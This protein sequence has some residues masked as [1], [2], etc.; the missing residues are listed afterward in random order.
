M[1]LRLQPLH[2]DDLSEA[3]KAAAADIAPS[4]VRIR[5][6][7]GPETAGLSVSSRV[8]TGVVVSDQREILTSVF[9]FTSQPAAVFVEDAAGERVAARV[10]AKDHIRKLVLLKCDEG[11]FRPAP[12][13]A[14]PWPAVGTWSIA[15]GRLFPTDQPSISVGIVSAVNRIHGLAIQTDAKI[16]PVN[17]G[18]PLV[19]LEGQVTGILVPLSPSDSGDQIR[20]GV[21][22]YD[23][24]I[25]FAIPAADALR[26]VDKLRR[27]KDLVRGV[28]GIRPSTRNPLQTEFSVDFV[29]PDSPAAAAGLE[30]GDRIVSVNGT[31]VTRFGIF[32]AIV[33]RSYAGDRFAL[34]IV[35]GEEERK[36]ELVLAEKIDRPKRG[37]LGVLVNPVDEQEDDE[38]SGVTVCTLPESAAAAA[39]LPETA[40]LTQ[41]DGETLKSAD[42]LQTKLR[43]LF[44][45]V[46]VSLR[47]RTGAGEAEESV[48]VP[49]GTRPPKTLPLTDSILKIVTDGNDQVN[50]SRKELKIGEDGKVWFYAPEPRPDHDSGLV[51]L[52]SEAETPYEAVLSRWEDVCKKYNLILLVPSNREGTGLTSEDAGLLPQAIAAAVPRRGIE[53]SRSVLVS[54]GAQQELCRDLLFNPRLAQIRA[55][56]FVECWPAV[57]GLSSRLLA[58]KSPAVLLFDGKI[59]SRQQR[60]LRDRSVTALNDAGAWVIRQPLEN[61]D[62]LSAEE[63]LAIWTVNLRAR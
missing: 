16:S 30:K 3:V 48:T 41:W 42:E 55:A 9:G 51:I 14:E 19:N 53:V 31:P 7:G 23:S 57:S 1:C 54:A 10:V 59:E 63:R 11:D 47:Y 45:G 29:F 5:T 39:G 21:Q 37:F 25:G 24:G 60:A 49:V 52:L 36:L 38:N 6:I 56:A 4:V 18:G 26:T 58:L 62:D 44:A 13:S 33:R 35:R 27:G 17:Y 32:D 22:W 61:V 15:L 43:S 34:N 28:M 12:L 46:D 8:T 2:A 40:V 20:A 50:W